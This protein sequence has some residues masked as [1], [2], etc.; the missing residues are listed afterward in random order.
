MPALRYPLLVDFENFRPPDVFKT[1]L[2]DAD[3]AYMAQLETSPWAGGQDV[4]AREAV[5]QPARDDHE[6]QPPSATASSLECRGSGLDQAERTAA[7]DEAIDCINFMYRVFKRSGLGEDSTYLPAS[8]NPGLCGGQPRTG[9]VE[10]ATEAQLV[11]CGALEGLLA[12]TGLAPADIDILVTTCSIYCPTPSLASMLINHFKMRPGIQSYSLSGMG[13]ANGVVAINLIRDLLQAHPN[14]NAV[15]LTTEITTPAFYRGKDKSRLVTNILFRMGASAM[16][17]SN[18]RR[19]AGR[20]K[21][22]LLH[23]IRTHTG[24]RDTAYRC[25]AYGPDDEGHNG[26][27]LGV[28]VVDEAS[29]ALTNAMTRVAPHILSWGQ[30]LAYLLNTGHKQLA[31]LAGL[32]RPPTFKPAFGQGVQHF[33]LHAGGAKVLE[34]LGASLQLAPH[35][36]EPSRAVLHDYGNV[37]SSSTWYALGWIESVR[38]V[39]RGDKVLQVGVGSGVKCGVNVWKAERSVHDLHAAWEHCLTPERRAALAARRGAG[40]HHVLR[41]LLFLLVLLALGAVMYS[42]ARHAAGERAGAQQPAAQDRQ[43]L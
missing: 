36:L 38:G 30:I 41:R 6:A 26:V 39:A 16:L 12:K 21:Y 43:E 3:A 9:L 13:C 8:L 1:T 27:S 11:L 5:Q 18:K 4:S 23:C 33:L 28:N 42:L 2:R 22:R 32:P 15:F 20:A 17:F 29:H 10:A 34:G 19:W 31:K 24:A 35:H 37:S 40:W 25:I 14:S 7:E